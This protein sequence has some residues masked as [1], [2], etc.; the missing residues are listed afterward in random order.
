VEAGEG[1]IGAEATATVLLAIR[2]P[3]LSLLICLS[4]YSWLRLM[5]DMWLGRA[6]SMV[7]VQLRVTERQEQ[8]HGHSRHETRRCHC[9]CRCSLTASWKQSK[10]QQGSTI[11]IQNFSPAILEAHRDNAKSA[12]CCGLD[13]TPCRVVASV[14][15]LVLI[16]AHIVWSCAWSKPNRHFCWL[17]AIDFIGVTFTCSRIK[18]SQAQLYKCTQVCSYLLQ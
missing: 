10:L 15:W 3:S 17:V 11:N 4:A 13:W 2:S 9:H 7:T 12:F 8:R 6:A 1:F 16:A 5:D 18:I 14:R